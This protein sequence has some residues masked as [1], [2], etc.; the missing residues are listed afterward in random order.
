MY[1][2]EYKCSKYIKYNG[3]HIIQSKNTYVQL[4]KSTIK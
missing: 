3:F 2:I 1:Y 4:D